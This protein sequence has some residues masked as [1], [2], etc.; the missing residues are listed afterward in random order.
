MER[1]IFTSNFPYISSTTDFISLYLIEGAPKLVLSW[2]CPW[3]LGSKYPRSLAKKKDYK[4]VPTLNI[5]KK[6][7][8]TCIY[9]D[10]QHMPN[11]EIKQTLQPLEDWN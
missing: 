9:L 10:Y 2:L 1:V 5:R 11:K 7:I 4:K 3:P 6:W 8:P